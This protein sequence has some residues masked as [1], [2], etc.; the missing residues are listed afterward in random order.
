[1]ALRKAEKDI[2]L[3]LADCKCVHIKMLELSD[4]ISAESEIEWIRRI[5]TQYN[6]IIGK[7]ETFIAV[8]EREN[9]VKHSCPLRLEKVKMPF[10]DGTIRQYPRF[11]K[12]LRNR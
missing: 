3:A 8:T 10:F 11:R 12:I 9:I 4:D 5:Q 2:E 6:D 7:I 1:M